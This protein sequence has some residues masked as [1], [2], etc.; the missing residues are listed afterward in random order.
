MQASYEVSLYGS[1]PPSDLE[2][3]LQRITLRSSSSRIIKWKEI[4]F[5]PI[6]RPPQSVVG[7]LSNDAARKEQIR[8]VCWKDLDA[9]GM[10]EKEWTLYAHSKKPEPARNET[11]VRQASYM[12]IVAG[13]ALGFVTA[14]GYRRTSE[15]L[16]HGYEFERDQ[17]N[18]QIFKID[19][20]DM[21]TKEIKRAAPD[22]FWQIEVKSMPS[23]RKGV[24]GSSGNA[25]PL[26]TGTISGT[27]AIAAST[28]SEIPLKEETALILE[29]KMI[30][31]GL[32][33]LK[34]LAMTPKEALR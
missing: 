25:S 27:G 4:V 33:D 31:K 10:V 1:F 32:L 12:Q 26:N 23:S 34:P 19:T 7:A 14:L 6:P 20:I 16:K 9:S 11:T 29:F 2:P 3:I 5:D 22:T 15:C 28:S 18:I 13:D 21:R 8:L 24:P 30:L 17:L